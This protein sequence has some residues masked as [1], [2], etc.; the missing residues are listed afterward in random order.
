VP[1]ER[2]ALYGLRVRS[3][4][5]L[6]APALDDAAG[7][8]LVITLASHATGLRVGATCLVEHPGPR[9]YVVH[10]TGASTLVRFTGAFE[11][12]V[13]E[14]GAAALWI[15]PGVAHE[16]VAILL[17]G[18]ALGLWLVARGELVLH[19]SA[20]A[21]RGTAIAFAGDSGAGKST[22]AALCC[23][24]GARHL[25]DDVLVVRDPSGAALALPGWGGARLRGR[26]GRLSGRLEGVSRP[27][28]DERLSVRFTRPAQ[29]L[30]L[31]AVLFPELP[32]PR[33]RL[34]L[35]RLGRRR[36]AARLF[37]QLVGVGLKEAR[38]QRI[39]LAHAAALARR[40]SCWR[41]QV[42]QDLDF[43]SDLAESLLA[44]LDRELECC[45]RSPI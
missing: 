24:A 36:A 13:S 9:G 1:A 31:G 34:E 40:V 3:P 25:T 12:C 32:A 17:A 26:A 28:I 38:L 44:T 39:A 23:S 41:L 14:S 37:E 33:A 30:P 22:L 7:D 10:R 45:A 2:Y 5:A 19:A 21:R 16:L 4:I 20:V 27:S 18:S 6:P 43:S 42:P 29:A 11:L 35:E 8:D 15:E